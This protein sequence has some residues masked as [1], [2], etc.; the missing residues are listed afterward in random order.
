MRRR[1]KCEVIFDCTLKW[2]QEIHELAYG[3][4]S[5]ANQNLIAF[6]RQ[7]AA[8]PGKGRF[9][10]FDSRAVF[11]TLAHYRRFG[12]FSQKALTQKPPPKETSPFA[13]YIYPIMSGFIIG[14]I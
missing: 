14:N 7:R 3:V 10:R 12:F 9:A 2:L 13:G 5:S 1:P 8:L 11:C 4:L 6:K